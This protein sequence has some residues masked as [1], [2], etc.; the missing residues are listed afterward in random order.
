MGQYLA[1]TCRMQCGQAVP[2]GVGLGGQS[3][4]TVAIATLDLLS[5]DIV[6]RMLMSAPSLESTLA[7]SYSLE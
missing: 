4:P 1:R 5:Y 2:H 3:A 6:S 7:R